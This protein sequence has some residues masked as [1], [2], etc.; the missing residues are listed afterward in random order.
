MRALATGGD[1]Y[2]AM[3]RLVGMASWHGG[4]RGERQMPPVF[5]GA[6]AGI[7]PAQACHNRTEQECMS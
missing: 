2:A 6:W 7:G 3:G 1:R 4:Q 5:E